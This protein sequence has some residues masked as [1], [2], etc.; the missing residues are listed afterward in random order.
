MGIF[1]TIKDSS[2]VTDISPN[3]SKNLF[4]NLAEAPLIQGQI[5]VFG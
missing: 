1:P 3:M 2:R 4:G 5:Q